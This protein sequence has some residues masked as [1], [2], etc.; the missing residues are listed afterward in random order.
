M[1]PLLLGMIWTFRG[2]KAL[3]LSI[4]VL[5]V[6]YSYGYF[7]ARDLVHMG[8]RLTVEEF[9]ILLLLVRSTGR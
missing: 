3:R 8:A 2:R 9:L 4:G 1:H 5:I 7:A 6:G